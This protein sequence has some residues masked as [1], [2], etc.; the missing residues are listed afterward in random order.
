MRVLIFLSV[1]LF[2]NTKPEYHV[3]RSVVDGDTIWVTDNSQKR[4]KIRL[5]GMDA[6]EVRN[7]A[8]KKKGPY[9]IQAKNYLSKLVLNKKVR[10]EYDVRRKDQYGRTLAYVYLEN[11]LFVNADLVKKGYAVV[12]TVS[13]NVKY[14]ERFYLLQQEART[15]K[16][17]LWKGTY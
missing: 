14:A 17:G 6:Q 11:G 3:V 13:P 1:F 10:L 16:L 8:K 12:Q 15:K 5:I 2:Q 7:S 9:G 4:E